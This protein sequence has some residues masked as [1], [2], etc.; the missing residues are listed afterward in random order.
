VSCERPTNVLRGS[1][2]RRGQF[3]ELKEP[4]NLVRCD[5]KLLDK[6]KT[7][8]GNELTQ[9][10]KGYLNKDEIKALMA[11]RDKIVAYFQKLVA[12]K[13]ESEVLY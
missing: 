11:R 3:K 8:D 12:E 9:K 4:K 1:N 10:T 13:G 5:Q 6:L 7:L 2:S